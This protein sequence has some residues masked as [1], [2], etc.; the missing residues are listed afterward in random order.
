VHQGGVG[1]A[2]P[3]T[4]V[5]SPRSALDQA[6]HADGRAPV[7]DAGDGAEGDL[8]ASVRRQLAPGDHGP[9]RSAARGGAAP[10]EPARDRTHQTVAAFH[11]L[12]AQATSTEHESIVS[13]VLWAIA[14]HRVGTRPDRYEPRAC[15]RRPK[16]Y[17][18]LRVPRQQA[19]ARL[20]TAA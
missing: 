15:K 5:G 11:S 10:G 3:G 12:L 6:D 4:V 1:R 19:R 14:H 20:A 7:Q 17:P 13:I 18:L 8:E 16:P 2:L 9:S